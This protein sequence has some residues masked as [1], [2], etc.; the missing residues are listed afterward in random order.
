MDKL[1]YI[2]RQ[3]SRARKKRYEHYVTTRIW[4]LL[5]DLTIKLVTQQYVK[6]PEGRALTDIYFP[7]L[8]IHIEIDENHHK[9]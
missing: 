5:N 2:A 9:N 1:D 4:H 8:Q 3:L 6:R 7:Q